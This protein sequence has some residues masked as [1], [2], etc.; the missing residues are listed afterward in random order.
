MV[1]FLFAINFYNDGVAGFKIKPILHLS[2]R[3]W[4]VPEFIK[5]V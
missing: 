1:G 3:I 2:G 4:G 5:F